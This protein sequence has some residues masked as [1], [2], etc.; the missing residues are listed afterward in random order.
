MGSDER[1]G[2]SQ[3]LLKPCLLNGIRRKEIEVL[4]VDPIFIQNVFQR[5]SAA[6]Q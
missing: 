1:I 4:R 3:A 2:A 5:K 6:D